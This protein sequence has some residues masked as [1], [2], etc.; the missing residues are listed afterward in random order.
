MAKYILIAALLLVCLP[1][2]ADEIWSELLPD[3]GSISLQAYKSPENQ[4]DARITAM[5]SWEL[6]TTK[7][8]AEL[9]E[10]QPPGRRI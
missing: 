10:C 6:G 9:V 3:H 8:E 5:G 4:L 2:A 1:V 7:L